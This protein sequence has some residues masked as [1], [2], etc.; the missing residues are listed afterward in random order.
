MLT[1]MQSYGIIGWSCCRGI[2]ILLLSFNLSQVGI[3]VSKSQTVIIFNYFLNSINLLGLPGVFKRMYLCLEGLKHGFN[4]ACR[5]VIGFDGTYIKSH[6]KGQILTAVGV[7]PNNCM[8]P[9]AYAV[10]EAENRDSWEWFVKLLRQDI[11]AGDGRAWTIISDRQKRLLNVVAELFPAAEHRF[12]VRHMQNNFK[13]KY[14]GRSL[15]DKMWCAARA[16]NVQKFN[17]YMEQVNSEL[18]AAFD[19]LAEVPTHHWSRPAFKCENKCDILL[20]NMCESFNRSIVVARSESILVMLEMIR[21]YLMNR[22]QKKKEKAASWEDRRVTPKCGLMIDKYKRWSGN[23]YAAYAGY[24]EFQVNTVSGNRFGVDLN[25]WT[26]GCRR[27]ELNGIPC[28]HVISAI[29]RLGL[30][31]YDFVDAAYSIKSYAQC[32]SGMWSI[33]SYLFEYNYVIFFLV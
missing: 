29:N 13:Q 12:C 8:Y 20:N 21:E 1:G 31:P 6:Y 17:E 11:D 7:D 19:W 9:L 4:L 22:L 26:C 30:D 23:V 14:P 28:H 27:W 33:M 15:K 18:P 32:Y 24:N 3:N 5:R 10:V 16:P 2:Q 25:N